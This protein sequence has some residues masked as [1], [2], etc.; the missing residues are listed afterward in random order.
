[1]LI[2]LAFMSN[3]FDPYGGQMMMMPYGGGPPYSINSTEYYNNEAQPYT[4]DED[5]SKPNS[6]D[7][8][9]AFSFNYTCC[10]F[11]LNLLFL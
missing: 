11:L 4:A 8:E 1:M 2:L 5:Q 7:S 3:G 10:Q 6:T 9:V